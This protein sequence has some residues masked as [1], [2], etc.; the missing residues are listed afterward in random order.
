MALLGVDVLG[1]D[2][3]GVDVLGFEVLGITVVGIVGNG[4]TA[5]RCLT[6]GSLDFSRA[7]VVSVL[8]VVA[9][10]RGD[11]AFE[12]AVAATHVPARRLAG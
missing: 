1:V 3:V 10:A 5:T 8:G 12:L 2:V 9:P 6:F 4:G 11:A 7:V